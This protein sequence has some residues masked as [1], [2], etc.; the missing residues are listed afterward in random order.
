MRNKVISNLQKMI[1]V[2]IPIIY[3]HDFDFA[4]I[5]DMILQ[6]IG[7]NNKD[8]YEWNPGTGVTDFRTRLSKSGQ[9]NISLSKFIED[10]YTE[11]P[12]MKRI[13]N[14]FVILREIHDL[15][16]DPKIKTLLALFAQRKL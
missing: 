9:E 8:I 7:R 3:I 14:K 13:P 5:D 15:I 2:N 1:D 11:E 6:A 16:E 10:K 4:R 12:P